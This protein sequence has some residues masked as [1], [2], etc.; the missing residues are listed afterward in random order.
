M[1]QWVLARDSRGKFGTDLLGAVGAGYPLE[2]LRPLLMSEDDT[3]VKAVMFILSEWGGCGH[4]S[5]RRCGSAVDAH[6]PLGAQ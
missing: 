1:M 6:L 3:L 4:P 2:R 5:A